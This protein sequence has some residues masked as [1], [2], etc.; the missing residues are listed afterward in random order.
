MK[1]YRVTKRLK[2]II[3]MVDINT[4]DT[5]AFTYNVVD[6]IININWLIT[7]CDGKEIRKDVNSITD[8]QKEDIITLVK[9]TDK[10]KEVYKRYFK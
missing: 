3:A 5:L 7:K 2:N 1:I 10:Y 9:S 6:N 4:T 8:K